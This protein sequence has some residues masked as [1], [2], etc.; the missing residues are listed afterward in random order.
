MVVIS[1]TWT[2]IQYKAYIY[3]NY[4]HEIQA[5][6]KKPQT[7]ENLCGDILWLAIHN[8]KL[9]FA[10]TL[11]TKSFSSFLCSDWACKQAPQLKALVFLNHKGQRFFPLCRLAWKDDLLA[12]VGGIIKQSWLCDQEPSYLREWIMYYGGS[13]KKPL[14]YSRRFVV[15]AF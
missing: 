1:F 3:H 2:E 8:L 10:C 6:K 14:L 12:L 4:M 15:G 11:L 7:W 13:K 9:C 5:T